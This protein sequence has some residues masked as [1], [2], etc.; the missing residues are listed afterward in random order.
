MARYGLALKDGD[1]RRVQHLI[2]DE[3]EPEGRPIN[4]APDEIRA[5]CAKELIT[6]GQRLMTKGGALMKFGVRTSLRERVA[7]AL[8][9]AA[10]VGIKIEREA[11]GIAAVLH[12]LERQEAM[13]R[14]APKTRT[15]R[16]SHPEPLSLVHEGTVI[17]GAFNDGRAA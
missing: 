12:D 9:N 6:L 16:R 1:P 13:S 11:L 8:Q 5:T 2:E 10:K 15:S 4:G 3:P 14:K 17:R 7:G